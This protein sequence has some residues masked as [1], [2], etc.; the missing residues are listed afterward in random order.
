MEST[1]KKLLVAVVVAV[2]PLSAMAQSPRAPYGVKSMQD[3]VTR[4]NTDTEKT[5]WQTIRSR[6]AAWLAP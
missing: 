5:R 3:E 2:L 6:I 4:A 1:L